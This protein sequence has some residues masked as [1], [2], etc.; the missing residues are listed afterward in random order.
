MLKGNWRLAYEQCI[1]EIRKQAVTIQRMEEITGTQ[2]KTIKELQEITRQ[3]QNAIKFIGEI[4]KN[5]NLTGSSFTEYFSAKTAENQ[6]LNV[7]RNKNIFKSCEE[8]KSHQ[9]QLPSSG[10]YW[11]DPDGKGGD[12][13]IEV[14]CN[15][16]SGTL[17]NKDNFF[18]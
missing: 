10:T 11:I 5:P 13:P 8:I 7:D 17:M 14:V 12:S 18:V 9:S 16:T 1:N 3:Q 2:A 15:M 6:L 4:L